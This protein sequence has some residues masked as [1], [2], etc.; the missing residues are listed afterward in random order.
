[1]LCNWYCLLIFS[2][3]RCQ[4]VGTF[5]CG[6]TN[7]I[8]STSQRATWLQ[9]VSTTL[10]IAWK[11]WQILTASTTHSTLFPMT[12]SSFWKTLRCL[13]LGSRSEVDLQIKELDAQRSVTSTVDLLQTAKWNKKHYDELCFIVFLWY[14]TYFYVVDC[15]CVFLNLY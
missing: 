14:L 3:R 10:K 7:P 1:M 11:D 13:E 2:Q 6:R 8:I 12:S 9:S 15:L 5:R 4:N